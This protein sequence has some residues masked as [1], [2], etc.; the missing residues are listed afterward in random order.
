MQRAVLYFGEPEGSGIEVGTRVSQASTWINSVVVPENRPHG[1]SSEWRASSSCCCGAAPAEVSAFK[2]QFSKTIHIACILSVFT[3]ASGHDHRHSQIFLPSMFNKKTLLI[4][5]FLFALI[6][7][8]PR[9]IADAGY[10]L[11]QPVTVS[12][13]GHLISMAAGERVN[14]V[15]ISNG[16]AWIQGTLP[17]GK[18]SGAQ[19]PASSLQAKPVALPVATVPSAGT[20][21]AVSAP[22]PPMTP[23][24]SASASPGASP[25]LPAL[26]NTQILLTPGWKTI[27]FD[28]LP[29]PEHKPKWFAYGFDPA[30]EKFNI[31]VPK[32]YD[33]KTPYGVLGWTNASDG[34]GIPKLFEPLFDEF[35]LIAVA[36]Q[37]CG[38]NQTSDRRAGLLA[39]AILEL[40]KITSINQKRLVLSGISGGGR[41]SALGGFVHPEIF[42]GAISWCGG[43]FYKDYPDSSKANYFSSGIASAHKI[44]D[45]VT[46]QN[47]TAA[48]KNV[49]FVLL[50]GTKD[51]NQRN[52][53]DIEDAMKK[54]HFQVLLIEQP[55]LGHGV[56]SAETMRQALEFVL[57][58]PPLQQ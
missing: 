23:L 29:T 50:T 40:S 20:I 36:A 8:A 57:G 2:S 14:V 19:V 21:R 4:A 58:K 37:G 18:A 7:T 51:F 24:P 17:D 26:P 39:S 55:D 6:I 41:L 27:Q 30:K 5:E 53:H 52:S 48:K 22:T 54:E 15:S 49:K 47:V 38:N 56:G 16:T 42:C 43:N 34:A 32:G 10:V 33:P 35:R 13:A 11:I 1:L 31:Y 25:G 44:K 12:A 28:A 45:A 46:A 9:V 3:V